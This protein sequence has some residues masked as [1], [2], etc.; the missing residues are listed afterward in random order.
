MNYGLLFFESYRKSRCS[1]FNSV[2]EVNIRFGAEPKRVVKNR[3][4]AKFDVEM[5]SNVCPRICI[6]KKI[7][8]K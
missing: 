5:I 4:Y 7:N 8:C 6:Y 1:F 3:R 2:S